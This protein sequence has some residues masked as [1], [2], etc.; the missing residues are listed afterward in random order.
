V[1]PGVTVADVN[2][3]QDHSMAEIPP[4][5]GVTRRAQDAASTVRANRR[6]WD[7]DADSYHAAH[8]AFLGVADFVW[9]PE[10]L[11][12][13]DAHLLG[14]VTGRLVLEV[15]CGAAMCSRWLAVAGARPVA[16]DISAGM[17]RHARTRA[18]DTGGG[19]SECASGSQLCTGAQPI[20]D[21]SPAS[22]NR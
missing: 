8:G 10:R 17:L 13:A 1:L 9:S 16:F 21:A 18:A 11:R 3:W 14:D 2:G 4:A 15:G 20:F 7:A 12:E 6:W 22:S 19:A 5:V